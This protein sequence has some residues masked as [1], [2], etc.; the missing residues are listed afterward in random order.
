ADPSDKSEGTLNPAAAGRWRRPWDPNLQAEWMHAVYHVAL[1]KPFVE[2]I[3]WGDLAD[4]NPSIPGGGLL[5]DMLKPK[6]AFRKLQELREQFHRFR[7]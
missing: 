2:S 1:S 6:P 4:I 5:D 3:A 7:K